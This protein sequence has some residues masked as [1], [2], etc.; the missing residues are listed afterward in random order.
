MT[1]IVIHIPTLTQL[2]K[3]IQKYRNYRSRFESKFIYVSSSNEHGS[4]LPASKTHAF[5]GRNS[6][7]ID[8]GDTTAWM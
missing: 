6:E 5:A 3:D 8:F 7:Y 2:Q 4:N 1:G